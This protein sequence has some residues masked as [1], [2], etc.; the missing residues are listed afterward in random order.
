MPEISRPGASGKQMSHNQNPGIEGK[1]HS[2]CHKKLRIPAFLILE[3]WL[4]VDQF[5]TGF[6]LDSNGALPGSLDFGGAHAVADGVPG[7]LLP[8][9]LRNPRLA[10]PK[11]RRVLQ[12]KRTCTY[13]RATP[14]VWLQL[15][16]NLEVD[17]QKW[18]PVFTVS[19]PEWRQRLRGKKKTH[20]G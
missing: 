12:H 16:L 18:S 15:I 13:L 10:K 1:G 19:A 3:A 4:W 5:E 7:S 2:P 17:M 20:N 8:R 9:T 14:K 11:A 6:R